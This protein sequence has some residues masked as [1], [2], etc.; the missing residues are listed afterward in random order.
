MNEPTDALNVAQPPKKALDI[1]ALFADEDKQSAG[2]WKT[3]DRETGA[4]ALIAYIGNP[5]YEKKLDR[6]LLKA[7]RKTRNR[8]LSNIEFK[9]VVIEAMI[10]TVL[11]DWRQFGNEGQPFV[12][13][14]NNARM[15][16]RKSLDFNNFV[17]GEAGD[18]TNYQEGH[19]GDEEEE[20]G[21]PA[22][23]A[24][25]KSGAPVVT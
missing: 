23:K 25:L 3:Y 13:N 11:L 17:Q 16:L 4:A 10:G 14:E 12:Y 22:D 7:R 1:K 18:I 15:F 2:V 8:E 19:E 5:A 9:N 21:L 20:G 6:L 24:A